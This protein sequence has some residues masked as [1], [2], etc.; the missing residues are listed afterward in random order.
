MINHH[1]FGGIVPSFRYQTH[2]LRTASL[3]TNKH[4]LRRTIWQQHKL[5]MYTRRCS[6]SSTALLKSDKTMTNLK[7][8]YL[9]SSNGNPGTCHNYTRHV[10]EINI[11]NGAFQV[12][13][14]DSTTPDGLVD[15]LPL[16]PLVNHQFPYEKL[17]FH[18]YITVYIGIPH[19]QIDPNHPKSWHFGAIQVVSMLAAETKSPAQTAEGH[20]IHEFDSPLSWRSSEAAKCAAGLGEWREPVGDGSSRSQVGLEELGRS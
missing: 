20:E 17:S 3:L 10:Q 8:R 2:L 4:V 19:L 13:T 5:S 9:R 15:R 18:G 7:L 12:L 16:H 11:W 6:F 1:L 14:R